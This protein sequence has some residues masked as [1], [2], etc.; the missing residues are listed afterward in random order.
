LHSLPSLFRQ[1]ALWPLHLEFITR[2]EAGV[3]SVPGSKGAFAGLSG[4]GAKRTFG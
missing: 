1:A 2:T 4:F 3:R